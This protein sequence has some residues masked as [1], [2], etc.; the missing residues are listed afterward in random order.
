MIA[1]NGTAFSND[2]IKTLKAGS[3][4]YTITFLQASPPAGRVDASDA[5]PEAAPSELGG[6]ARNAVRVYK[7]GANI[8][9]NLLN[10]S[11]RG[12]TRPM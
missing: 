10:P 11:R 8:Y 12:R 5:A 7:D 4:S 6:L 3:E 2:V 1:L 9:K